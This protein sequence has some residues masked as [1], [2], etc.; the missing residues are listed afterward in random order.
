VTRARIFVAA[1][2]SD[3]VIERLAALERRAHTGLRWTG[4]EQW[5][6]TLRFLGTAE[7][8]SAAEAL[9]GAAL[10]AAEALLG[11]AT[12]RLG[13]SILAAPVAGLDALAGAVIEATANV[14][15]PPERRPF[16]GHVTLARSR[17]R[18][19]AGCAGAP[20]EG[21]WAV[22]EIALVAS[23]LHPAGARY[24]IVQRFGVR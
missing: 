1:W 8:E 5:H 12:I 24:E 3:E 15:R 7:I 17:D 10:P 20:I 18:V 22:R 16:T 9:E 2:P 13:R 19:P 11:P 6:V 4:R 21:R 23:H 14:G